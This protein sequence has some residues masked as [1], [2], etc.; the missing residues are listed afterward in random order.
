MAKKGWET[1]DLLAEYEPTY[2]GDANDL[3][4]L[5]NG[6]NEYDYLLLEWVSMHEQERRPVIAYGETKYFEP[7]VGYERILDQASKLLKKGG[8]LIIQTADFGNR[9]FDDGS[10]KAVPAERYFPLM[11]KYGFAPVIEV[12]SEEHFNDP[13]ER[14]GGVQVIYYA[15]RVG[16]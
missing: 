2:V 13:D 8:K 14:Y 15:E 16:E 3:V 4:S 6:K 7:A 11:R 12:L 10:V 9:I 1:N 5:T